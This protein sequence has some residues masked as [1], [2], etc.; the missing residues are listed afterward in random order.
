M[1]TDDGRGRDDSPVASVVVVTIL[2]SP[3]L[4]EC[5]E[6]VHR[7][8]PGFPYELLLLLNGVDYDEERL[9]RSFP[10]IRVVRSKENLG[11][12]GGCNLAAKRAH[13]KYL[14]FLNDDATVEDGWLANLVEVAERFPAAAAVGGCVLR[15]DRT[16]QE[17]G[18]RVFRDGSTLNINRRAAA[19]NISFGE[20]RTVD[21]C[22][23]CSL[24]VRR[25]EWDT[26]GGFDEHYF[27]AYY[28]DADLCFAIQQR[29]KLVLCTPR[30]RVVHHESSSTAI[31][32]RRD[33]MLRHRAYFTTKWADRLMEQPRP[34]E[35]E[36]A[37]EAR[38]A[39]IATLRAQLSEAHREVARRQQLIEAMSGTKLWKIRTWLRRRILNDRSA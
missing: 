27:P 25:S 30:S 5:L 24:L 11:F 28:E 31:E 26:V 19:A 34:P 35:D 33:L 6:S 21:Y 23:A 39:L 22:S 3:V 2:R 14:V 38:D 15:P 1:S 32:V 9:S 10:G 36:A 18:S 4:H 12:A 8:D 7:D 16:V 13:G 37:R 20:P 17:L 29:R